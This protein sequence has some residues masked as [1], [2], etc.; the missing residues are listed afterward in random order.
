MS[1][2]FNGREYKRSQ[3]EA[4][5]AAV[6]GAR[7]ESDLLSG[8]ISKIE[9]KRAQIARSPAALARYEELYRPPAER[10]TMQ[11]NEPDP[12]RARLEAAK[13]RYEVARAGTDAAEYQAA[14]KAYD[15]ALQ[16]F[17][18]AVLGPRHDAIA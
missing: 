5:R 16:A 11:H 2:Y 4:Q 3:Q 15:A 18:R 12:L 9:W 1:D 17:T 6:I 14:L 8:Q 10:F 13:A 7:R